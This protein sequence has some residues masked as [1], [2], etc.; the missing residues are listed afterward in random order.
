MLIVAGH[1][2]DRLV[3]I[4]ELFIEY[5]ASLRAEACLQN[6]QDELNG[7][8]GQYAPPDGRLLLALHE[9]EAAGCVALRKH[10]RGIAE[11][12]R[13]YVRP[14]FRGKGYGRELAK[15]VIVAARAAGYCRVRLDTLPSMRSALALYSSLGFRHID[16]YGVDPI[17]GAQFRE[18]DLSD[19]HGSAG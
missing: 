9:N 6:F 11:M 19:P 16:P 18:L 15:A 4:R 1:T 2:N 8:P 13:L 3:V 12:K 5:A 14:A 17:P 10:E 7:L